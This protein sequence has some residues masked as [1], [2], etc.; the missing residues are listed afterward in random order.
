M[1]PSVKDELLRIGVRPSK[2][3]GQNFL[4][5]AGVIDSIL[6][7][8]K[9]EVAKHLVEIG[10][11]LGALTR[12]L[13]SFGRVSVI[14]IEEKFC[15]YLE[16]NVPNLDIYNADV[17]F[18]DFSEIGSE[19]V[20]FGN[21]P[22]SFSTEIIFRLVDEAQNIKRAV[23]LLQKEFA[24]RLAA[25]PGGRDYGTLT[26]NAQLWADVRL[27][28]VVPGDCFHPPASV[29]SQVVELRFRSEPRYPI[30][31]SFLFKRFVKAAFFRRR[32]KILN[33]LNASQA[34]ADVDL[35]ELFSQ[36]QIDFN[37]RPEE[38]S[39][40]EYARIASFLDL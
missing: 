30:S 1:S 23:L 7:F 20:V 15:D 40:E 35:T 18:F 36:A 25:K 26:I 9:P 38:L 21:L 37:R 17:R 19:L 29:H 16:A 3:R 27:G 13:A 39:I 10:P 12:E 5:E 6:E 4:I 8:G 31:N 34:F 33:S 14:E 24:E 2:E 32:K 11:G 22:Y 28:P